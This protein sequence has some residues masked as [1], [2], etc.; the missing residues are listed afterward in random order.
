MKKTTKRKQ[1]AHR[2]NK[3]Q[4]GHQILWLSGL[5]NVQLGLVLEKGAVP[6]S[7]EKAIGLT[8]SRISG[9]GALPLQRLAKTLERR[10]RHL[11]APQD[12]A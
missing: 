6:D 1:K 11:S 5:P 4:H 3:R 7:P 12:V 10:C 9:D 8:V 2:Q